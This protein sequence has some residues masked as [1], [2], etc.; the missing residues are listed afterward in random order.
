MFRGFNITTSIQ[1]LL[2]PFVAIGKMSKAR[3]DFHY[4][5]RSTKF[6][7]QRKTSTSDYSLPL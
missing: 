7:L 3:K 6:V 1:N 4:Y 2:K 5:L